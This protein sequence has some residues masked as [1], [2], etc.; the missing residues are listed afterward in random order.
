VGTSENCFSINLAKVTALA[1]AA[2]EYSIV[3]G[4]IVR[5]RIVS[6]VSNISG[7]QLD[8]LVSS[9]ERLV[10]KEI[11][12]ELVPYVTAI[13]DRKGSISARVYCLVDVDAAHKARQKAME[14]ALEEQAL[15]EKYGSMASD[16]IKDGF[17]DF[18]IQ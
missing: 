2:N 7:Q 5:G 10:L 17:K 18:V 6:S 1:N 9:F 16:W 13:R 4:G 3:A 15:A 11:K 14:L 8:D 12:G